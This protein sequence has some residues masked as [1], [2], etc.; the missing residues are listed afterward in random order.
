M[1]KCENGLFVTFLSLFLFR[2]FVPGEGNETDDD[3]DDDDD[4]LDHKVDDKDDV[5]H[6][7]IK[8]RFMFSL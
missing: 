6:D 3:K 8:S 7:K 1:E 2:Y 5:C 4:D